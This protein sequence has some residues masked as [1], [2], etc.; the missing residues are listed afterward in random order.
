MSYFDVFY[1]YMLIRNLI[2]PLT[3]ERGSEAW[4]L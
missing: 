3:P 4:R 2:D 1:L